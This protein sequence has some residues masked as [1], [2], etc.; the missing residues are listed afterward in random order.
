[1]FTSSK[2][3]GVT[4]IDHI[5]AKNSRDAMFFSSAS[6]IRSGRELIYVLML[7][8]RNAIDLVLGLLCCDLLFALCDM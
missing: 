3:N 4:K 7:C 1:M 2:I 8:A 6:V 5:N